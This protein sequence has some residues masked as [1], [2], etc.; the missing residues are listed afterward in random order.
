MQARNAI[1][2]GPPA[3][4]NRNDLYIVTQAYNANECTGLKLP[5]GKDSG[6][7]EADILRHGGFALDDFARFI[8]QF[9]NK[10]FRDVEA[11]LL[12]QV[13]WQI[14]VICA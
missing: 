6:S 4:N 12:S 1:R 13:F 5:L 14:A 10:C 11:G 9:Y 2:A 8:K 7:A 3:A